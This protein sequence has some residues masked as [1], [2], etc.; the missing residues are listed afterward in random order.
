M[1][2]TAFL[3][4][5]VADALYVSAVSFQQSF[6]RVW[7]PWSPPKD[8]NSVA[9]NAAIH[10][11]HAVFPA[12]IRL[13][14]NPLDHP[15]TMGVVLGRHQ[16]PESRRYKNPAQ[17]T[18]YIPLHLANLTMCLTRKCLEHCDRCGWDRPMGFHQTD[19]CNAR[20]LCN[21]ANDRSNPEYSRVPHSQSDIARY[22]RDCRERS[23]TVDFLWSHVESCAHCPRCSTL[24]YF[25][26]MRLN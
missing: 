24:S 15:P 3:C 12:F 10:V 9:F 19:I 2:T 18:S 20:Q 11:I 5:K 21:I 22:N 25:R 16:E 1:A 26:L 13:A 4:L 6:H 7:C 14:T 8:S 17:C 23:S